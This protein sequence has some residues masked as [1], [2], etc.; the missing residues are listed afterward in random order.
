[1]T[2][3]AAVDVGTNSV[4]LLVAEPGDPLTE[5][6]RDTR[7][8]RLGAGVDANGRLDDSALARTLDCIGHYAGAWADLGATRVR[9]AATSAVRDAADRERFF[10]GAQQ[11]SGVLPEVLTGEQEA[12]TAFAGATCSVTGDPPFLVLDIGGGST[13]LILGD[14]A[15]AAMVSRQL[16]CVRLTESHLGG[17]PPA[18]AEVEGARAVIDG[19]LDAVEGSLDPASARTLVGVAGTVTTLAALHLEL[20]T[21]LPQRIHGTRVPYARVR[22]LTERL[23]AM[24]SAEIAAL[25][26]VAPGRE[27]VIVGGALI[28]E[29]VMARY[30]FAD[31]LVSEADIL[32]GLALELLRG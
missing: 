22:A 12:R 26:P 16:G 29:R 30:G 32:D 8:T 15:P 17:N 7:I 24:P 2:R 13:E 11:R 23:V 20:R 10:D 4:R 19:H 28:L 6:H 25:G 27:D 18:P 14:R 31:V 21:Y 3:V 1:M 9:I 5:I